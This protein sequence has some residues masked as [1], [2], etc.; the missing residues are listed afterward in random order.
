[1]KKRLMIIFILFAV[2]VILVI[3]FDNHT[4]DFNKIKIDAEGIKVELY[5]ASPVQNDLL[6]IQSVGFGSIVS[7]DLCNLD[8]V[9][10]L[11]SYIQGVSFYF[12]SKDFNID[13]FL[14][15]NNAKII[16]RQNFGNYDI[17]Y[18]YTSNLKQYVDDG[19]KINLEIVI[20]NE[21]VTIGYPI[22]MG[23]Y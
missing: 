15:T 19:K 10:D 4:N 17:Y 3:P 8:K 6:N 22:I 9:K 12:N 20:N 5:T 7:C 23:S 13:Y 21:N 11:V 1:M 16:K 2:M 14:I 18:A